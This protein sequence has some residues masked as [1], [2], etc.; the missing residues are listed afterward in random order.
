MNIVIDACCEKQ[1]ETGNV[2]HSNKALATEGNALLN[3]LTLL[4]YDK[5]SPPVADVLRRQMGLD[6]SWAVLTPVHWQ[7]THNDAQILYAGKSL[8]LTAEQS[9]EYY[10]QYALFLAQEGINLQYYNEE[11]WLMSLEHQTQLNAKP[12]YQLI[13]QS[14]AL[15]LVAIDRSTLWQKFITESQMFFSSLA[16]GSLLNGVWA[17]GTGTIV[18][19]KSIK[20]CADEHCSK[21]IQCLV[22]EIVL[23]TPS[24]DLEGVHTVMISANTDL[25][26]FHLEFLKKRKVHWYWNDS[27][28]TTQHHNRFSRFWRELIHAH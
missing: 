8:G 28:Y 26:P 9:K 19:P 11:Y 4:D 18:P 14:L 10:D 23:Y 6:G 13:N 17:W 27:A 12:V 3:L 16:K 25:S 24:I 2:R 22:D 15:E 21:Q 7:A 5:H 1:Q 20:V